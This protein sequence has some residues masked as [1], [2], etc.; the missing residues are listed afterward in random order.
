[1][2]KL[3]SRRTILKSARAVASRSMA[4]LET[5]GRPIAFPEAA[6]YADYIKDHAIAQFINLYRLH[7]GRVIPPGAALRWGDETEYHV[8]RF[9]SAGRTAKLDF[10]ACQY[11]EAFNARYKGK[12]DVALQPEYGAWMIEAI[13][14]APFDGLT[15]R[16]I[17]NLDSFFRQRRELIS[18]FLSAS[19]GDVGISNISSFPLLGVG[20]YATGGGAGTEFSTEKNHDSASI[21]T[22]DSGINPHPRFPTLTRS[23]RARRGKKVAISVPLYVDSRTRVGADGV[24]IPMDSMAFGM[25]CCCFQLTFDAENIEKARWL[26]DQLH[27]FSPVL[28]AL[29]A[30]APV[31]RGLLADQDLRYRVIGQCVD[32]RRDEEMDPENPRYISK[33]RYSMMNHYI[34]GRPEIMEHHND[35][36]KYPVNEKYL[37]MLEKA[38][39]DSRL[40]YHVAALCCR[41]PLVIFSKAIYI[42]DTKRVAHFENLQTTNWNSVRF[43]PPPTMASEIGWRVEFRPLDVQ[44]TDYENAAM[45]ALVAMIVKLINTEG[46]NF[47]LPITK[48]DV[49]ME[50]AHKR[51][52]L[53]SQKFYFR[54]NVKRAKGVAPERE[55]VAEMSISEILGGSPARSYPGLI[56]LINDLMSRERWGGAEKSKMQEYLEFFAGRATGRYKTGAQLIRDFITSHKEYKKDSVVTAGINYDLLRYLM[57]L[58]EGGLD[59]RP[60]YK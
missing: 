34:S 43:K 47:I 8:V 25:G 50:R 49:N 29:S 32:D 28:A 30:S 37:A 48:C 27:V 7:A 60:V 57:K 39:I 16:N 59:S 52:A 45:A 35:A 2:I 46:L 42:D 9:D 23:I 15:P 14:G 18:R 55:S 20:Q 6:Q 24:A 12:S 41:D 4:F 13:P 44:L 21:Y 19:Y 56:P 33:S 51:S 53:L 54:T 38:G 22:F 26:H 5:L 36:R 17:L 58:N 31:Y 11:R 3:T 10:S 40:A 1:M